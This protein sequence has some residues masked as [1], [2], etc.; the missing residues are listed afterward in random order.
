[1]ALSSNPHHST[2]TDRILD[3]PPQNRARRQIKNKRL[4]GNSRIAVVNIQQAL[5]ALDK[6]G[7][8]AYTAN[9]LASDPLKSSELTPRDL[10]EAI[11]PFYNPFPDYFCC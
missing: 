8:Q 7:R 2:E 5:A 4:S 6:L 10:G 3:F 9:H 11:L 1:L